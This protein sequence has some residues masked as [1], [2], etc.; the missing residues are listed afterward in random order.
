MIADLGAAVAPG[1]VLALLFSAMLSK[2]VPAEG[3]P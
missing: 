3:C 1:A 2:P